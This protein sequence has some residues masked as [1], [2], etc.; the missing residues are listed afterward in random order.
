MMSVMTPLRL[1]EQ[2]CYDALVSRDRRFDGWFIA[3]IT[4]TG[5]YCRAS[6]P[7]PVRPKRSNVRF[8]PT[9]AAAQLD[10]FRSCKRCRPD[11]SPGSPEWDRR[12]DLIGRAMRLIAQGEIDRMGVGGVAE[13]L[14]ISERHLH[15]ILT[16]AVGAGPL[17][18]ARAQRANLARILIET[19]QIA[20]TDVAFA[21]GFSSVRQFN[22]TIRAVYDRTP[23]QLRAAAPK[24]TKEAAPEAET[25][26]S[27]LVRLGLRL[28]ARAP[29]E[30]DAL[31]DFFAGHGVPGVTDGDKSSHQ[32][33]LQLPG[34]RSEIEVSAAEDYVGVWARFGLRDIGDLS[35]AIGRTR[36]AFDLDADP[37]MI[38]ERLKAEPKIARLRKLRPGIRVPGAFDGFEAA[39]SAIVGQQISVAGARTLL[40]RL[41]EAFADLP[42]ASNHKMPSASFPTATQ[43][44]DAS[45]DGLGLTTRRVATIQALANAVLAGDL[46]LD[47]GADR[48]ATREQL[49]A[50]PGIGPW[51]ADVIAMRALG[52]PDVMLG[53]DLVI[54][55]RLEELGIVDTSHLSPWRSYVACTL[56]AT[57]QPN[58]EK[59]QTKG[60]VK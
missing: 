12:A 59:T 1:D 18:L 49:L 58:S 34:G 46:C 48:A 56:W 14:H 31:F 4:S 23:T 29:I 43:L 55:R 26:R 53:G 7:A 24:P 11:A 2:R 39:V 37:E 13:R 19:T 33:T 47:P 51:T 57:R 21:A 22:D 17:A 45:L 30:T 8:Y 44:S 54:K 52:D 41:V 25:S 27:E 38:D 15:R 10:G 3:G 40:G 42:K 20:V 50:L 60:A 5:I 6:C 28:P 9:A 35:D 36:R 32:R 16:Q